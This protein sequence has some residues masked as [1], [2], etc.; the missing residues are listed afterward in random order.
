LYGV[1]SEE[2]RN[3][4]FTNRNL[5]GTAEHVANGRQDLKIQILAFAVFNKSTKR[6]ARELPAGQE[7]FG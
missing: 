4:N 7:N 1:A 5:A 3:L 6:T 2:V